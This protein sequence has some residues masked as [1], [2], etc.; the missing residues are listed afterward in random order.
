ML[1]L[2]G[3]WLGKDLDHVFATGNNVAQLATPVCDFSK[4]NINL[5]FKENNKIKLKNIQMSQLRG[6]TWQLFKFEYI[7]CNVAN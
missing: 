1:G 5:Y 7:F 4:L 3:S 6:K 2:R